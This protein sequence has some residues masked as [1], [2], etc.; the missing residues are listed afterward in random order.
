MLHSFRTMS[1]T[2]DRAP[3]SGPSKRGTVSTAASPSTIRA[4]PSPNTSWMTPFGCLV[5]FVRQS[6]P[7]ATCASP[8]WAHKCR[9][10]QR[11]CCRPYSSVLFPLRVLRP[12]SCCGALG[13]H[14]R[15][16][17]G[18]ARAACPSSTLPSAR[19]QCSQSAW[20]NHRSQLLLDF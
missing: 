4:S 15:R 11:V 2:S 9:R 19:S 13:G 10:G 7:L 1:H 14:L 5:S 16:I 3:L 17:R 18:A 12:V 6:V 8:C 20:A